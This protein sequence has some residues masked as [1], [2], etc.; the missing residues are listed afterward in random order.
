MDTTHTAADY[1]EPLH[2]NGMEGRMLRAPATGRYKNDI[3][4]VY[5]HHA[6]LER[7]WGLVQNLQAYGRVTMPDL[8]GFGGMDSFFK[9][10]RQ[11]TIDTYADYLAAFVKMHYKRRRVTLMGISFGFVVITRMLQRYPELRAKVDLVVSIV[12][13]MHK[14][15]FLFPEK[16]RVD[17]QI[18][19]RVIATAPLAFL[20]RHV[21]LNAFVIKNIYIRLPAGR[22]RFVAMTPE[23]FKRLMDFEVRL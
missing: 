6:L 12:G 4:L 23:D 7:W 18:Y 16:R 3:L 17:Y 1:I 11:P 9:I 20:I 19:T 15:D 2:V 22:R 5:G 10:G 21:A 14:G 8:P 13:F